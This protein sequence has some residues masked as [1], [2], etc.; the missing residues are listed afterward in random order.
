M[1]T[2]S[3]YLYYYNFLFRVPPHTIKAVLVFPFSSEQK[4]IKVA[5]IVKAKIK[6]DWISP[7]TCKQLKKIIEK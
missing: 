5:K 4:K 3:G 6:V 2:H 7:T 1:N